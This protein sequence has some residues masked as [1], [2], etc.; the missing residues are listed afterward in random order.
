MTTQT[1]IMSLS[2]RELLQ[3]VN[4]SCF[5]EVM[6]AQQL[7]YYCDTNDIRGTGGQGVSLLRLAGLLT[8]EFFRPASRP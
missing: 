8:Q 6:T 4:S 5:G 7:R 2:R 3:I 1:N